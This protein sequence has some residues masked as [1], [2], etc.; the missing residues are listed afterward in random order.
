MGDVIIAPQGNTLAINATA[1]DFST[2]KLVRIINTQ[3]NVAQITVMAA[4][5]SFANTFTVLIMPSTEVMLKKKPLDQLI[6]NTNTGV[7]GLN[8]GWY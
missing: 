7:F 8:V 4:N 1:N 6:C 2:A 3:A 5:N